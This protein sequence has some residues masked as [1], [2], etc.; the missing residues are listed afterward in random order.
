MIHTVVGRFKERLGAMR[1]TKQEVLTAA[2]LVFLLYASSVMM[3]F[4]MNFWLWSF[5]KGLKRSYASILIP[6]VGWA[7]LF[8][9]S[10]VMIRIINWM[11][12]RSE[13]LF[14]GGVGGALLFLL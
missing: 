1:M 6:S 4:G 10:S 7:L 9:A 3:F 2:L 5:K 11:I 14:F 12:G 13:N 8:F